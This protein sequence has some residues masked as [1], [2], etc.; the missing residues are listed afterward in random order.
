MPA[1]PLGTGDAGDKGLGALLCSGA[2]G[3]GNSVLPAHCTSSY[4]GSWGTDAGSV[5]SR[6]RALLKAA[7]GAEPSA[8]APA[9]TVPETRGSSLPSASGREA[10]MKLG[11]CFSLFQIRKSFVTVGWGGCRGWAFIG[12]VSVCPHDLEN[13]CVFYHPPNKTR[14]TPAAGVCPGR[15]CPAAM[16]GESHSDGF[17]H[18]N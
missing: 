13:K 5:Q 4:A 12:K 18:L 10:G 6:L 15:S 8:V 11:H 1:V 16:E 14:R 2:K 3:G 17:A 9:R 7:H